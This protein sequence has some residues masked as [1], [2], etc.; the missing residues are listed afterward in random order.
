MQGLMLPVANVCTGAGFP[1]VQTGT[2]NT[3]GSLAPIKNEI[4][5]YKPG[6]TITFDDLKL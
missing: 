5:L 4:D 6:S 1:T 2:I 3:G